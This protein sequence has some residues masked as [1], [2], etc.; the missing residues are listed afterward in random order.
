MTIY[1]LGPDDMPYPT[2]MNRQVHT[3][4]HDMGKV[5]SLREVPR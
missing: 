4:Q 3:K 5:S 2:R 1:T